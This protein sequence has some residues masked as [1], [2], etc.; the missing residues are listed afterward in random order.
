[1]KWECIQKAACDLKMVPEAGYD[2]IE[3]I[4]E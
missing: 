3:K 4:D 2:E 1:M